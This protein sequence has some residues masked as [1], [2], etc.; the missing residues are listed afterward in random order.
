MG[1]LA[2]IQQLTQEEI[3]KQ[4]LHTWESAAHSWVVP[5]HL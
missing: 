2:L 3:R 5:I 1:N 4:I